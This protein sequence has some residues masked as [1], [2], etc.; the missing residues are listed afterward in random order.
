MKLNGKTF[1]ITGAGGGVGRELVL[2]VLDR[3]GRVAAVDINEEALKATAE[4]A[5]NS[6]RLS[7]HKVD[8]TDPDAVND[9]ADEVTAIHGHV[10]GLINNAGII[11]PFIPIND[12]DLAKIH[13]VMDVN[14][15]GTVYMVKAFLPLLLDRPEAH[16]AN[17]SSMGGF[18]PVPG[19]TA[20]G[21]SK[22]AVTM[23]SDGLFAELSDTNVGVS[24]LLPGGMATDIAENSGVEVSGGAEDSSMAK[25][26]LGA[27]EAA[28]LILKAIEK[29]KRKVYIGK[30]SKTM[31]TLYSVAPKAAI[32]MIK[33]AMS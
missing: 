32:R 3:G 31:H 9:L 11:Q 28:D 15:Y 23:L 26:M 29:N 14:F 12:L 17:I 21:A 8:I 25:M 5:D 7:L 30:D 24:V 10:D 18:L 13:Q 1:V 6:D 2:K 27:G 16:I 22:A 20:Y 4:A 19:Q 33:K